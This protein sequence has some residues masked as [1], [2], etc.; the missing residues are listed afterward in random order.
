[1]MIL[2]LDVSEASGF[3]TAFAPFE[4]TLAFLFPNMKFFALFKKVLFST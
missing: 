1:M 4:T 3:T 2:I